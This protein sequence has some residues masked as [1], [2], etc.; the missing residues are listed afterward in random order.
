MEA[1]VKRTAVF[2]SMV[3]VLLLAASGTGRVGAQAPA[4]P[5]ATSD[6]LSLDTAQNILKTA[7]QAKDA[8]D[9]AF[10]QAN[11]VVNNANNAV[12]T[13][14]LLLN[15]IQAAS[16]FG[17]I[18]ASIFAVLGTR[19][20]QRTLSDYREELKKAQA[21]LEEM[22][23]GLN[24][25]TEQVRVQADRAIRAL[26]LMQLGEQQLERH[27]IKGALQMYKQAY[28]LDSDNGAINY[29]LGELYIQNKELEKGIEHL[30]RSLEIDADYAPAEAALGYALRIQGDGIKDSNERNQLYA[31]SEE[32][33]LRAL[34]IDQNALD[35]HG[36]PVQAGLGALYKRQGRIEQAIVEYEQAHNIAPQKSYPIINLASLYYVQGN[37]DKARVYFQQV[38]GIALRALESNPQDYWER[39]NLIM[40]QLALGDPGA[41][42][43][44]LDTVLSQVNVVSP[45]ETAVVELT[46][47]KNA[48][49]PLPDA[50]RFIDKM[51]AA[52]A[53]LKG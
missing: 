37:L 48:P 20:G 49:K 3:I 53:K 51:N 6:A 12:N 16:L 1:V 29:F 31:K 13:V 11:N 50:E 52:S 23:S 14:N 10:Q 42:M 43:D 40:G 35:I 38:V 4:T 5:A 46:R 8:A 9:T 39:L 28:S 34:H 27:N 22:H 19:I 25:E 24:R 26:A 2:V 15:F 30:Q 36:E 18:L 32:R 33:M 45:L 21:E 47:L 44:N 17:G 41:A 7:Q